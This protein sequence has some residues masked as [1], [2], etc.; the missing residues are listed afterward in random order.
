[1]SS[2]E[3]LSVRGTFLAIPELLFS[4]LLYAAAFPI[5]VISR[6]S[7]TGLWV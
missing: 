3:G 7:F 4:R 2:E 5:R 6:K 1:M